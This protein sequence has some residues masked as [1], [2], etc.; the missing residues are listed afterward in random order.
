MSDGQAQSYVIAGLTSYDL[1]GVCLGAI[2]ATL[3]LVGAYLASVLISK[4]PREIETSQKLLAI[5]LLMSGLIL[6]IAGL[7]GTLWDELTEP[8]PQVQSS[9]LTGPIPA[10]KSFTNLLANARVERLIKLIVRKPGAE[11]SREP[12]SLG[13]ESELYTLVGDF[14]EMKGR[15]A[16]DAVRLL[17]GSIE[18]GDVVTA[19]MFPRDPHRITPASAQGLLQTA[20]SA[21]PDGNASKFDLS[22]KLSPDALAALQLGEPRPDLSL[23][24][25]KSYGKFY[26]DYCKVA[27]DVRCGRGG[28][29]APQIG[30]VANWHPLGFAEKTPLVK[31]L[32]ASDAVQTLC[33]I[34]NPSA[35]WPSLKPYYGG[36]IFF[37]KNEALTAVPGRLLIEFDA[38]EDQKIPD[39]NLTR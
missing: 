10:G 19:I 17:G 14:D 2:G 23:W 13:A 1:I 36:R 7:S 28:S 20:A 26:S 38:P 4:D 27:L 29:D 8:M 11:A 31:D 18:P 35:L 16:A 32:C 39:L 12:A 15:T 34:D 9:D 37:I 30:A 25:W 3:V 24:A 22:S 5:S 21:Q 6:S 33:R